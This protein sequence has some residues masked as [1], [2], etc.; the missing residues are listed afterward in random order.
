MVRGDRLRGLERPTADRR[1]SG[2]PEEAN[3]PR[4]GEENFPGC[5]ALKSHKTGKES[6]LAVRMRSL[7]LVARLGAADRRPSALSGA[8][9]KRTAARRGGKFSWLQSLEMSQNW[10][11]ISPRSRHEFTV[12]NRPWARRLFLG[13]GIGGDR[14]DSYSINRTEP[15]LAKLRRTHPAPL[16]RSTNIL[17][18]IAAL[19]AP[20]VRSASNFPPIDVL[21]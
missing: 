15:A 16:R 6:R 20:A 2:R 10:D 12:D 4:E 7:G 21:R 5:K 13:V 18:V 3:G 8:R 19:G 1:L 14:R 17:Q 11:G 9:K